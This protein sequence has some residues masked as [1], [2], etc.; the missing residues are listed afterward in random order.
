MQI[1]ILPINPYTSKTQWEILYQ[2]YAEFYGEPMD[3]AK[4]DLV[5][6]WLQDPAH[7]TDGLVANMEGSL[8]GLAHYRWF[9]R[10][11]AGETGLFLDDLFTS[12]EAR[13]LGIGG[14]ILQELATVARGRGVEKVRWIT[15]QDNEVARGLYDQV[16]TATSWVTYDMEV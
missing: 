3:Q 10:P 15:A 16:A 4:L 2:G 11:L 1:Q 12:P 7:Q 13:G 9:A 5:W 6:G 14:K 8:V